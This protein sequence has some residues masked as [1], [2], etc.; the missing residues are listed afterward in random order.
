[1]TEIA[2]RLA[3]RT[4]ALVRIPSESRHEEAILAEIRRHLPSA[5]QVVDDR[6]S[7]LLA[8]PERRPGAPM[9]LLA[10]HVDTV[11]IAGSAPGR[12]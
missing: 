1:M 8:L 9:I 7:V 6:D 12:L 2:E 11:P 4:E 3:A 5:Y 10:G